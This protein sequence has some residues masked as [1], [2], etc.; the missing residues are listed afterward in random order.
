[1]ITIIKE[2]KEQKRQQQ[3]SPTVEIESSE[4]EDEQLVRYVMQMKFINIAAQELRTSTA[5]T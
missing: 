5:N 2:S 4:V 1:V 3:K